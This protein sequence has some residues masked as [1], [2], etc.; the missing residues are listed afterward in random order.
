[1]S[2]TQ[3]IEIADKRRI[4]IVENKTIDIADNNKKQYTNNNN[5]AISNKQ[6]NNNYNCYLVKLSQHIKSKSLSKPRVNKPISDNTKNILTRI[7]LKTTI[8]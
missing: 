6:F 1:M 8:N 3:T 7:K 4:H 5:I 2:N